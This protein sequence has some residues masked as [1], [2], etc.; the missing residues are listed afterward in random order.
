MIGEGMKVR[1]IP[2]FAQSKIDDEAE[3]R[4]KTV[5]GTIFMVNWEHRLFWVEFECGGTRQVES[6]Q[7]MDIGQAVSICGR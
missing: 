4:R 3:R 1:F 7:F 6:F 5:T 2:A